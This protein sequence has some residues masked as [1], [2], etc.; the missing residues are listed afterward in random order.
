MSPGGEDERFTKLASHLQ[1]HQRNA[2]KH[3]GSRADQLILSC[4]MAPRGP[5][6]ETHFVVC[7]LR[8]YSI[9]KAHHW[10]D[11][12]Q[13]EAEGNGRERKERTLLLHSRFSIGGKEGA[14]IFLHLTGNI[15]S[16]HCVLTE[17]CGG[18]S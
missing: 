5:C 3:H 18:H 16:F 17:V 14:R 7:K 2:N 8:M 9:S 13:G 10:E 15:Q 4:V 12:A 1:R 11:Q 6:V